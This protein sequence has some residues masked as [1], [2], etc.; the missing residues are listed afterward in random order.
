MKEAE[1]PLAPLVRQETEW[2]SFPS[3]SFDWQKMLEL[4]CTGHEQV[5]IVVATAMT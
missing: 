4:V 3:S 5:G 2:K 1:C